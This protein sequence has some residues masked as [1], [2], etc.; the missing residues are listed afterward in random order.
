LL[1][2]ALVTGLYRLVEV[3]GRR[4]IRAAGDRLLGIQRPPPIVGSQGA[5]AE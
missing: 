3:P 5:P 2:I 1:A 4:A